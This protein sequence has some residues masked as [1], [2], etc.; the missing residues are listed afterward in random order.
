MAIYIPFVQ[1]KVLVNF[2]IVTCESTTQSPPNR[3]GLAALKSKSHMKAA[4]HF[5]KHFEQLFHW[6]LRTKR[7]REPNDNYQLLDCFGLIDV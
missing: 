7:F 6:T 5:A 4:V 1:L 2:F 3:A